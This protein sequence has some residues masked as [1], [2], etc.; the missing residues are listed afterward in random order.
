MS[1]LGLIALLGCNLA[2]CARPPE[3][4]PP[5]PNVLVI[6]A[7]TLRADRLGAY[8]S[9]R[10]LTPFLDALAAR[11]FVFEQAFAQSPWTN[12]SVASLFTSRFQSQH[13][14]ITFGSQLPASAPTLAALLRERG[15]ATGGFLANGLLGG[16]KGF[17]RGF[18]EY[19]ALWPELAPG[20]AVPARKRRAETID[21]LALA[22]LDG[23]PAD[24]ARPV[25]L[26]LH[27]VE[28]HPPYSPPPA[29]LDRLFAGRARPDLVALS[30]RMMLANWNPPDETTR[31]DLEL[32][33]D[34][35]VAS[36][37][38]SLQTLFGELARRGFLERAVV[39]FTSDHGE[40][41]ADHG[42]FGHG[43]TLYNELIRVPLIVVLPGQAEGRRIAEVV[44]LVDVAPTVL[45]LAGVAR[46]ADLEGRSLRD[47]LARAGSWWVRLAFWDRPEPVPAFSELL[48]AEGKEKGRLRP[49]ESAIVLGSQKLIVGPH[50]ERERYDLATDPGEHTP[51][52]AGDDTALRRRLADLVRHR[53]GV[54][55]PGAAHPIDPETERRLRA[56]GYV[57]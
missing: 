57:N 25:F 56:F 26:Y 51:A 34:A 12:P 14:V 7:D 9:T 41:F 33:Y 2:G 20:S 42:G 4:A 48:I 1:L 36:L 30:T 32:V 28:P 6:L 13:G 43:G 3:A 39:V 10:G 16:G 47:L 27:Y 17:E 11:G 37:D 44:S 15:Y 50:G 53:D 23:L 49:H 24:P 22:W 38:A 29:V 55:A 54:A 5:P 31:H 21:R 8:G 35:E 18:D 19:Q 45:D 40:E 52:A 46:P